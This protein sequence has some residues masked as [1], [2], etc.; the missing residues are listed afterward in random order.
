MTIQD[1]K[2]LKDKIYEIEGLLELAQLR[3]EKLP[4]LEPLIVERI[5]ALLASDGDETPAE[6][7]PAIPVLETE[8]NEE[9]IAEDLDSE[10]YE[11]LEEEED[12]AEE[13][14]VSE[15]PVGVITELFEEND[16]MSVSRELDDLEIPELQDE[17]RVIEV[18]D[19]EPEPEVA[20]PVKQSEPKVAQAK[21]AFTLNDRFRFRR[22][23]FN[24]SDAAYSSA[25]D[26]IAA[27][28][29]YEEAEEYFL[30]NLGWS[31]ENPDVKDF[32]DILQNY[33]N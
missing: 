30:D 6:I 12:A 33:F 3:E 28:E 7:E 15:E 31:L 22:E 17:P 18:E 32:M 4:E 24:N 1:V 23:L 10:A 20:K 2:D 25:M 11:S 29:S 5:K 27:M 19:N 13:V 14:K 16:L 8:S 21:P 9:A 26:L